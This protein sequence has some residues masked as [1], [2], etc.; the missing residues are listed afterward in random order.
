[1]LI[2]LNKE[3]C[4]IKFLYLSICRDSNP[5]IGDVLL[6]TAP[7]FKVMFVYSVFLFPLLFLKMLLDVSLLSS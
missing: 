5:K 7:F 2:I 4:C 6:N 3:M 1:M